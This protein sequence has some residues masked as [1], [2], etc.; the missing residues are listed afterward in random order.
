[1]E[2]LAKVNKEQ[3]KGKRV[4]NLPGQCSEIIHNFLVHN[5][6]S[7]CVD[8]LPEH[9]QKIQVN[10]NGQLMYQLCKITL[11]SRWISRNL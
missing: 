9:L 2:K 7:H 5:I 11:D 10:Y 3:T 4:T 6:T 1:M 8:Y